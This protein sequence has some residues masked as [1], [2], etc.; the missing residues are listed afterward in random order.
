MGCG[1][2]LTSYTSSWLLSVKAGRV[3]QTKGTSE[4]FGD[5]YLLAGAI[6]QLKALS[7]PASEGDR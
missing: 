4:G 2:R 1:P 7:G 5:G 6:G 3:I